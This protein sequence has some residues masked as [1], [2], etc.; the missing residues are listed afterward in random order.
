MKNENTNTWFSV[1]CYYDD[2]EKLLV[3]KAV[4]VLETI[5]N[6]D[7]CTQFFFSKGNE[8]GE[9]LLLVFQTKKTVFDQNIKPYI[10]VEME[11]FFNEFPA[12]EQKITFPIN[13]WFL[14][15]P[16]NYLHFNNDYQ[17]DLME[18]GGLQASKIA[19]T[20][21][22]DAS[23]IILDSLENQWNGNINLGLAIQLQT[24]LIKS[25]F[26]NEEDRDVFV[27]Y[28]FEEVLA[29]TIFE[30][31]EDKN[32][33]FEGLISNYQEQEESLVPFIEFLLDNDEYD[34]ELLDS[35]K[36]S[37]YIV[38][39]ILKELQE[40]DYYIIP[41]NFDNSAYS[42]RI[43]SALFPVLMYYVKAINTQLNVGGIYELNLLYIMKNAGQTLIS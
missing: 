28:L 38:A 7:W 32:T 40:S 29:K 30:S 13:D 25:F 8:R 4:N 39:S 42:E 35:W 6:N 21:L 23:Q 26:S 15:L 3:E 10:T 37:T 43:N 19:N 31:E 12:P 33:L 22:C 16:H 5:K 24:I 20:L 18:T 17:L 41:E 27:T 2:L 11:K 14:P 34:D 36:K 1:G 9:H